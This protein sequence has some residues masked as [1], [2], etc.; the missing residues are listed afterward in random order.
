MMT[1][2]E[3]LKIRVQKIRPHIRT[4]LLV[5]CGARVL[6]IYEEYWVGTYDSEVG[7]SIEI[8]WDYAL[9]NIVDKSEFQNCLKE[10]DDIAAFYY[11]E[12]INILA[13]SVTVVLSVLQ[14]MFVDEDSSCL[15]LIKGLDSTI[16][17]ANSAE[18]MADRETPVSSRKNIA[19]LE[20]ETWQEKAISLAENWNGVATL[21]MFD[22]L[23]NNP[24][25]WLLDW[26]TRCDL[27]IVDIS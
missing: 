26:R 2:L 24:P 9:G 23:G 12:D 8:G 20:E 22:S 1:Q 11:E 10:L 25:N 18:A 5:E 15:A 27:E 14:S 19:V 7:R 21:N 3:L 13:K 6:P 17:A 16:D 4:A